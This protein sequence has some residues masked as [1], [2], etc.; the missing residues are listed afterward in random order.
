MAGDLSSNGHSV[1]RRELTLATPF[2]FSKKRGDK[3]DL[4]RGKKMREENEGRAH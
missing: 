3:L 4:K 1:L 2:F